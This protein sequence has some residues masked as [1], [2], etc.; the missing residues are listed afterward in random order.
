MKRCDESSE[1]RPG[2]LSVP[3]ISYVRIALGCEALVRHR[4]RC[5]QE[6][7]S[8]APL[9]LWWGVPVAFMEFE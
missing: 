4:R 2:L 5:R 1:V 6:R 8:A 9:S 3:V 7:C